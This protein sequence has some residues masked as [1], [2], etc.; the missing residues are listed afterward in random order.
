MFIVFFL[1]LLKPIILYVN[2]IQNNIGK[3]FKIKKKE[4]TIKLIF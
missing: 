1:L 4:N 3:L 2:Y